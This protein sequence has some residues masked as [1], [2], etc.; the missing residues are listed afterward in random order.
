MLPLV[1]LSSADI[2]RDKSEITFNIHCKWLY[3]IFYED[4]Q[5]LIAAI[6]FG[7]HQCSASFYDF[8]SN[9]EVSLLHLVAIFKVLL[10]IIWL[11]NANS[12]LLQLFTS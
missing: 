11:G 9:L 4:V 1:K 12:K 7:K 8:Q 10:L 2:D 6:C 3:L 5:N